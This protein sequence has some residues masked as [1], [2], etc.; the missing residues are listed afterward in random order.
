MGRPQL[1]GGGWGG[2]SVLLTSSLLALLAC[3]AT[4]ENCFFPI[5]VWVFLFCTRLTELHCSLSREGL[6]A[7]SLLLI[8]SADTSSRRKVHRLH[9]AAKGHAAVCQTPVNTTERWHGSAGRHGD[10]YIYD[11]C[12]RLT[13]HMDLPMSYLDFPYVKAAIMNTHSNEVCGPCPESRTEVSSSKRSGIETP[14]QL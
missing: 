8:N 11:R 13:F 7:P 1:K 4:D 3:A 12:H 2:W 10:V 9:H 6:P 14:S 5:I